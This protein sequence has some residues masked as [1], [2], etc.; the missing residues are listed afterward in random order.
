[1]SY[2]PF[3]SLDELVGTLHGL[4][5]YEDRKA[6]R[7]SEEPE[8]SELRFE[9]V[10]ST[11]DLVVCRRASIQHRRCRMLLNTRGSTLEMCLP[12]W[13]A[14]RNLQTRFSE[15]EFELLWHRPFPTSEM[16]QLTAHLDHLRDQ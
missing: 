4:T 2:T 6:V 12:F 9:R 11:M 8:I 7:I 3:D 13:R 15:R 1:M 5:T 16:E 14:L 10:N